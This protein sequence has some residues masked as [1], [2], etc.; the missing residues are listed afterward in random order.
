MKIGIFTAVLKDLPLEEALARL[1]QLGVGAVE[2]GS[3]GYPGTPHCDPA[4]LLADRS[5]KEAWLSAV[6]AH[7]LEISSLSCHGNPLHP[8]YAIGHRHHEDFRLSVQLA[9]ELGVRVV[10]T[11]SGCPGDHPQAKYPNWVSYYWPLDFH[12]ILEWQWH[13]VAIPYWREEARFAADHGVQIALEPH[14]G[15][16]V[17]NP[18]TLLRLRDATGGTIGVNFDPSH[19]FWQGI[20]PALAVHR[21]AGAIAHVH[22]KDIGLHPVH[23]PANGHLDTQPSSEVATRSWLFRTVGC[24]HGEEWWAHFFA[25]LRLCGYD[26]TVSIEH[27]DPLLTRDEGLRQAVSFLQRVVPLES[28]D[29]D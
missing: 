7:G 26:G 11:F 13:Q 8:E 24:G 19:F 4:L 15:F 23:A 5:R 2:F 10:T 16:L 14:P 9:A 28:L 27:E 29:T 21:L 1:T 20:D 25:A 12:R 22:A 6:A 3:G 17:Y 18:D